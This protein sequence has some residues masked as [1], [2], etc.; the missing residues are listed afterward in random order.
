MDDD[1]VPRIREDGSDVKHDCTKHAPMHIDNGT[2][3]SGTLY[4]RLYFN[5]S[6]Q[7]TSNSLLSVTPNKNKEEV[8]QN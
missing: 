4:L 3:A 1:N 2:I 6:I 5:F 8:N 7:F